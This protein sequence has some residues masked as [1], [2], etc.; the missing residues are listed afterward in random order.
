[1]IDQLQSLQTTSATPTSC[2]NFHRGLQAILQ[3]VIFSLDVYP[4][5]ALS[6]P[7]H[8]QH[9]ASQICT[10]QCCKFVRQGR[11][12]CAAQKLLTVISLAAHLCWPPQRGRLCYTCLNTKGIA[13]HALCWST[14]SGR[15][16]GSVFQ[17]FV[18]FL[19]EPKSTL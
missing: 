1:M 8:H 17:I 16:I 6:E 15:V 19:H 18:S 9:G 11:S 12:A 5:N 10:L 14:K 3:P 4:G 7:P 13:L 2:T